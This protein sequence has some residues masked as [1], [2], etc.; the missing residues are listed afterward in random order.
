MVA[1]EIL[2][3]AR[4]WLAHDPD[5]NTRAELE[6]LIAAESDELSER[7][8]GPLA[9]GTAGLRGLLGAGESRMNRAVVRRTSAGLAAYLEATHADAGERGVVIGYDGRRLSREFAEDT[10]RV[11][12]AAGIPAKLSQ[13]LCP[14]PLAAYAVTKLGAV[15]GVM[16]TASHNPPDYN[17][18]KV[19]AANGAQIV[20]PMDGDIA[21]AIKAA[22]AADAVPMMDL[23]E[24]RS[25]GLLTE[26][27]DELD[28]QYLSRITD[29]Y[30]EPSGDRSL[31]IV[32][33]AMHGVGKRLFVETMKQ[34]GFSSLH[35]VAEQ[36]EPD[37]DFPTVAFP[38]P[39]EPG[40][41]DLS[42]ALARETDAALVLAHDPDA[43]RLAVAARRSRGEY[44]QLT[45]NEVGALLGYYLLTQRDT[46]GDRTVLASLV[47][48]PLLG[49]IAAE[50]G[51][52][53]EETLTG[54]KW[55][56]NRAMALEAETGTRF[57][58]GFEE[59]LGYTVGDAVRD[60]DGVSAAMVF[61][62]MA[63]ELR[64]KGETVLDELQRIAERFGLFASR[65]KSVVFAG[66][67][68]KAKM[69]AIMDALRSS[70]PSE[71]GGAAVVSLL[72]CQRS[73]RRSGDEERPI[74]MPK[75]NVL[76][77]SL[78]GGDRVIV[79]PS[80]TEPKIKFYVDVKQ[81]LAAGMA[82]ADGQQQANA[83]IDALEAAVLAIAGV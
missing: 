1:S 16:V 41:L 60:K 34:V 57:V 77:F 12:C 6:A 44:Q 35:L 58:F 31:P 49:V 28:E 66:A 20:P 64:S 75:S 48:S 47:S 33:T 15:A 63:A 27:G 30:R 51:V 4:T 22:P 29:G 71:I 67:D 19:Y 17:G 56:A 5:P 83:R 10:A 59:A 78:D 25:T 32:Y 52:R 76:V 37:G 2:D 69:D 45:G 24:A 21:A 8:H 23:D 82:I 13:G 50:L 42:L 26:F 46:E 72:D 18:Y 68:G 39:E 9:F 61:A 3:K 14:T 7:F 79:R 65:Q 70:P 80:G 62:V 36:C 40:A 43:D 53:Y 54:F 81:P 11:M 73:I 74:D 38:N 55:I